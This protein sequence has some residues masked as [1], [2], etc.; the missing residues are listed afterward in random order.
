MGDSTRFLAYAGGRLRSGGIERIAWRDC[1]SSYARIYRYYRG[2]TVAAS[3]RGH[4]VMVPFGVHCATI[5]LLSHDKVRGFIDDI[6]HPEWGI[7]LSNK[8]RA[9]KLL[10]QGAAAI[11][12][13]LTALLERIHTNRT[14]IYEQIVAA[15]RALV[16]VTAR[17]LVPLAEE[18]LRR[19]AATSPPSETQQ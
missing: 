17:N 18:V 3:M 13:E 1:C 7:E 4:G 9:A 2:V 10:P 16:A 5:S 15:Q 11:A 19:A 8:R 12:A 14:A 6:G